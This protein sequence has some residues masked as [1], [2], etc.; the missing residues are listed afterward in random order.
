MSRPAQLSLTP[1]G[2]AA[3]RW[4]DVVVM[5]VVCW[6]FAEYPW[7]MAV[8]AQSAVPEAPDPIVKT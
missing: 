4:Q 3:V 2:V 5:A 7:L 6:V 1:L 8:T